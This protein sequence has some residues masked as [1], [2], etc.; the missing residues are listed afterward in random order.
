MAQNARKGGGRKKAAPPAE[1]RTVSFDYI[2]S[3]YFRVIHCDGVVGGISPSGWIR[4]APWNARPPYP[5][6]VVHEVTSEGKMGQE[7]ARTTRETDIVRE[8]EVDI[9]FTAEM[10]RVIIRWLETRLQELEQLEGRH[11]NEG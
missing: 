5:K 3:N 7:V 2:K 10:A 9:V 8:L 11:E 6:Q 4:M 1:P